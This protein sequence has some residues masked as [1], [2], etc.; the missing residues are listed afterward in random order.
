MGEVFILVSATC[1][2]VILRIFK[3]RISGNLNCHLFY[4]VA[5]DDTELL[6]LRPLFTEHWDY[7]HESMSLA[8]A[9]GDGDWTRILY[10]VPTESHL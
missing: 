4:F 8:Y 3:R 6:V 7:S 5:E 2:L 1:K 9:V 10:A